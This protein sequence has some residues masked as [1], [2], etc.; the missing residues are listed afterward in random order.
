MSIPEDL[1]RREQRLEVI[2]QAKAKIEAR[3]QVRFQREQAEY[4]AKM[5]AREAQQKETGKKPRGR[6]PR[7]PASGPAP[8]DQVN[9][10]DEGTRASCLSLTEALTRATT[11]KRRWRRRACWW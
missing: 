10:T 5:A 3:A 8:E 4:Q 2:G 11:H 1:E 6:E 7:S 9:L